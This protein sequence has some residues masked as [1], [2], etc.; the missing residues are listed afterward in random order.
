MAVNKKKE[1]DNFHVS[2]LPFLGWVNRFFHCV[3][4]LIHKGIC[5]TVVS[6][7]RW[8]FFFYPFIVI[9]IEVGF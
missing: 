9:L 6:E 3:L 4:R 1:F 2:K 7:G 5:V 8:Q